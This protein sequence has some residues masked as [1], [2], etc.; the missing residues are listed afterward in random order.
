MSSIQM[1]WVRTPTGA[2]EKI[3]SISK[4]EVLS[5]NFEALD[6]NEVVRTYVPNFCEFWNP[7]H[8]LGYN[9]LGHPVLLE[10]LNH[11]PSLCSS[12]GC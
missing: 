8:F 7:A 9:L 6:H 3:F 4:L 2:H 1:R 5:T 10:S 11:F 12:N